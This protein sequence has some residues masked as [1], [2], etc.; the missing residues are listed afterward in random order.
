MCSCLPPFAV[1]GNVN[2]LARIEVSHDGLTKRTI[3]L[4]R[5]KLSK[6]QTSSIA[7]LNKAWRL[8]TSALPMKQVRKRK[9]GAGEAKARF[10]H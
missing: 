6:L 3:I 10:H 1:G 7:D 4:P 2:D 9:T 8:R 5:R